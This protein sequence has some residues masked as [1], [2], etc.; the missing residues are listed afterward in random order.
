MLLHFDSYLKLTSESQPRSSYNQ[1]Y[2][3][4]GAGNIPQGAAPLL[5]NQGRVIQTGPIRILCIADVRGKRSTT[6]LDLQR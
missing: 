2:L 1:G 6:Q 4:N 3:Q 5:P